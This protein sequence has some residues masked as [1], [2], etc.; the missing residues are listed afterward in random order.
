M[1]SSQYRSAAAP[2]VRRAT[3][4]VPPGASAP[5]HQWEEILR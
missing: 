1:A 4:L 2:E 5:G 3:A